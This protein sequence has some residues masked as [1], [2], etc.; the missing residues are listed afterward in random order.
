M[1]T[2]E[3]SLALLLPTEGQMAHSNNKYE[4]HNTQ[5]SSMGQSGEFDITLKR[6]LLEEAGN[7]ISLHTSKEKKK[8]IKIEMIEI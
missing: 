4:P 6:G 7:D 1:I 8:E 5:L 2:K 3:H